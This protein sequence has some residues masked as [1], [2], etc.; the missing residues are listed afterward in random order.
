MIG[1]EKMNEDNYVSESLWLLKRKKVVFARE[2][3]L[4]YFRLL[5]RRP[6]LVYIIIS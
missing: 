4:S 1:E 2:F 3:P 5:S 6:L